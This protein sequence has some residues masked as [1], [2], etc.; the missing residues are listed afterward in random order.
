MVVQSAIELPEL[1]VIE[2]ATTHPP[3]DVTI[4]MGE[5]P[6]ALPQ[7]RKVEAWAAARGET[8][9]L[10]FKGI[11]RFLVQNGRRIV[12]YKEPNATFSDLRGFLIGSAL[13]AAAHQRRLVPLHVSAVL[14]PYGAVAFTGDSGAGKSTMAAH[15]NKSKNWPLISD[16]VSRLSI[17]ENRAYLESG[18]NTVKLWKDALSSLGKT[19]AGLKRDLTRFDKYHAIE[20]DSFRSGQFPLEQLVLLEWG[21]KLE[22]SEVRGKRAFEVALNSIYRPEL[23]AM[24]GNRDKLV[25]AAI[26]LAGSTKISVLKRPKEVDVH[27]GVIAS[28]QQL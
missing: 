26:A 6:V 18:V 11:G 1:S 2:P 4:E 24:C 15:L 19:S 13:A 28:I 3:V 8:C 22:K 10:K 17:V 9:L 25:Q 27:D 20:A 5:V 16:D 7:Q 23:A 14:S 21:D 12:A